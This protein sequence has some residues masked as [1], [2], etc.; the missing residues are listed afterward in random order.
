MIGHF[1]NFFIDKIGSVIFRS[2]MVD[3]L[4]NFVICERSH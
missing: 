1:I 3:L 2:F 4:F